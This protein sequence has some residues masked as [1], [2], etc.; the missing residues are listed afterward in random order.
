MPDTSYHHLRRTSY[1]Y[2][3]VMR[4]RQLLAGRQDLF[5]ALTLLWHFA[6]LH[7]HGS[8]DAASP[9]HPAAYRARSARR[10]TG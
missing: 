10:K 9:P 4:G 8:G 3:N 7:R 6:R 2:W 5:D 1:G